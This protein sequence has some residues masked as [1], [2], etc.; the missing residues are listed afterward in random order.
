MLYPLRNDDLI[1]IG[2]MDHAS[3]L[4]AGIWQGDSDRCI[5]RTGAYVEAITVL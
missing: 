3:T 1:P 2:R 4:I 5:P